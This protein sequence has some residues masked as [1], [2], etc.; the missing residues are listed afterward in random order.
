MIFQDSRVGNDKN[1]VFGGFILGLA[2]QAISLSLIGPAFVVST[3][4]FSN[5]ELLGH[6]KIVSKSQMFFID[7][8]SLLVQYK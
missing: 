3:V 5:K 7:N 8:C 2:L 4:K 6:R 1:W